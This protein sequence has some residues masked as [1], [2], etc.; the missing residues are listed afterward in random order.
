MLKFAVDYKSFEILLC[1]DK[2]FLLLK[3]TS[4]SHQSFSAE[5]IESAVQETS[6]VL[7]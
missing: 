5:H 3:Q 2:S 7:N 1:Q 6:F 4:V